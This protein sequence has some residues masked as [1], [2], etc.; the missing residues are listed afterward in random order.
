MNEMLFGTEKRTHEII[1]S[2][3]RDLIRKKDGYVNATLLCKLGN[4]H[5]NDFFSSDLGKEWVEFIKDKLNCTFEYLVD[6]KRNATNKELGTWINPNLVGIMMSWISADLAARYTCAIYEE[7]LYPPLSLKPYDEFDLCG[8]ILS[9]ANVCGEHWRMEYPL[10]NTVNTKTK[11]R[12]IDLLKIHNRSVVA[13]ELKRHK[14]TGLDVYNAVVDREYINLLKKHTDRKVKLI[15][16]SPEPATRD[17]LVF[18]EQSKEDIEFKT[19]HDFCVELFYKGLTKTWKE[20]QFYL[21]HLILKDMYKCLFHESFLEEQRAI[22][23]V[24]EFSVSA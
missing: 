14:V 21:R 18:I 22:S 16:M 6:I 3:D 4:K 17:A 24:R 20:Q 10:V 12:R 19:V 13:I 9:W 15:M 7:P 1:E 5:P 2:I 11:N 23:K 8:R